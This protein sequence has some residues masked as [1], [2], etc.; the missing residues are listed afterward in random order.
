MMVK[1]KKWIPKD[2]KEGAL[3]RTAKKEGGIKKG[4]GIKTEFLDKA[5]K[6]NYG[7]TTAKRAVLAKTF[8]KMG[9]K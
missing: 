3:T 9:K 4:G 2:L 7:K 1:D 6:G 8:K 5:A